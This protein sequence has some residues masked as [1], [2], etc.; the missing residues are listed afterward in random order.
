MEK[1][2]YTHSRPFEL[3][4]GG[5]IEELEICYHISAEYPKDGKSCKEQ[6]KVIWITHALTANSDPCDWWM[7]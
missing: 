7:Y 1:R 2:L 5:V 6:K 3:E 4:C